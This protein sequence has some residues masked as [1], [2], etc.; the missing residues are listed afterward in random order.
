MSATPKRPTLWEA[1]RMDM[2]GSIALTVA[3]LLE[4]GPRHRHWAI[5]WSGGKDSTALVTLVVYLLASGQVPRPETLTILYADTRLEL[6]PLWLAARSIQEELEAA[7]FP[8]RVVMAPLDDRFFVYMLG[9]GVPPPSNT[10]RWCTEQM[11]I[12]P[13]AVAM[14]DVA[15]AHGLGHLVTNERG[16]VVYEAFGA[17]TMLVLT[18]VRR[19]ESVARD[20]RIAASCA[21]D[22]AECGQGWYQIA[23]P[24]ALCATLAPIDHWRV[25]HVWEWLDGWAPLPEFGDWSTR[26]LAQA[27]GGRDGDEAAEIH[28][29]TGCLECNLAQ[30]D[31]SLAAVTRLDAWSYLRGLRA[32]R[33]LWALLK[34]PSNRL[35][36]PG[37]ERRKDGQLCAKQQRL[38]PLTFA[39]RRMGLARVLEIQAGVNAEADRL[40]RPHVDILNA[41]EAARIIAL[42]DAQTWPDG[43]DGTEPTGDVELD[44]YYNNGSVQPL[45]WP[46]RGRA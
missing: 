1:D 8:V 2:R 25:C 29:R 3:S 6:L 40:G 7:G 13:M 20:E 18:G 46:V 24:G 31:R 14:A 36:K 41:E 38:G 45:L 43:W 12:D 32:L 5:A 4:H 17:E 39:T 9:R 33:Q 35:R 10:F 37:G 27:Y 22:G 19:G 11:K 21:K 16:K 42:I 15:V 34:L 30:E 26:A 28:A 23:L 44:Q